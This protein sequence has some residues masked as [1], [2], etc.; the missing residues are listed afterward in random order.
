MTLPMARYRVA[1]VSDVSNGQP[2]PPEVAERFEG[3]LFSLHELEQR[4]VR[5]AGANIYFTAAGRDW[6][7]RL[8][9]PTDP[10]G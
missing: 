7:L 2:A 6:W 5:I 1:A 9:P 10:N 8:E 4:G 3:R